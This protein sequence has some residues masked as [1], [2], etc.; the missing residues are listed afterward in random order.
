MTSP[1]PHPGD[2]LQEWLDGRLD[3]G[4]RTEVEEHLAACESCRRE[5]DRLVAARTLLRETLRPRDLPP[6]LDDELAALIAREQ[7]E[8]RRDAPS[9]GETVGGGHRTRRVV[10]WVAAA[11]ALLLVAY[12]IWRPTPT[13]VVAGANEVFSEQTSGD[14]NLDLVTHD[15]ARL[16]TF[17]NTRLSFKVK[18][19]DLGMMGYRLVGGRIAEV[20]GR[21]T[22]IAVYET[23]EG[24]RVV[25]EMFLGSVEELPGDTEPLTHDGIPFFVYERDGRTLAFW[26]E[27]RLICVLIS[28]L[29]TDEL[30]Q[31]AFAKAEKV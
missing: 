4:R 28:D 11:A 13:T 21:E 27:G 6:D 10:A 20:A 23:P 29:P 24:R 19:Y 30:L 2:A 5:R 8:P 9:G 1:T 31:L 25:C 16:E 26:P 18:V 7:R 12:A 17:F 15:A 14:G 22:S 3:A